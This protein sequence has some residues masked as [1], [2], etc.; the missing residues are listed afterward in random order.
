VAVNCNKVLLSP[1]TH[2]LRVSGH[3]Q[4]NI[5]SEASYFLL[6]DGNT[7]SWFGLSLLTPIIGH[8][9]LYPVGASITI[10]SVLWPMQA[11]ARPYLE[12]LELHTYIRACVR[13]CGSL[14]LMNRRSYLK[15]M[16]AAL[17]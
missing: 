13:A 6:R 14:S 12:V 9:R 3:L 11:E 10:G 2:S 8:Y 17:V 5:F 1:S 7:L 15:G 16:V 4:V